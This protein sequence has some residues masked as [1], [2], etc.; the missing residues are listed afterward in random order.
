MNLIKVFF[1]GFL[2]KL[3]AVILSFGIFRAIAS[4]GAFRNLKGEFYYIPAMMLILAFM[5]I[6]S[7]HLSK[8]DSKT[9]GFLVLFL[10]L[11]VSLLYFF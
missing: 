10:C 4:T 11:G 7:K 1:F 3:S 6:F 2:S 8:A 5:V 9:V